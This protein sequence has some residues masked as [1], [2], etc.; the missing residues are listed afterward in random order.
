[1]PANTKKR[2]K[3][4]WTAKT[5]TNK[6]VNSIKKKKNNKKYDKK[7]IIILSVCVLSVIALFV[8]IFTVKGSHT[9][10]NPVNLKGDIAWGV[11]VSA[12][13][14]KINWE[15]VSQ[16]AEFAFIRVGYS[17]WAKGETNADKKAKYNL[18]QA[19]K[20]KVPAGVYYYSQATNEKEAKKEAEFLLKKIKGYDV[21]LP[22]VIDF[23]YPTRGKK[24]IGRLHMAHLSKKEK[25]AV[26][27]AFCDRVRKAGYT[28]GVYA[29][30]AVFESELNVK[31]FPKDVFI[32]VADYNKKNSYAG[33][34]DIWQYTSK[35]T[36][37][38]I[39]SSD[40]DLNYFYIKNRL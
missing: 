39:K 29:S 11:D 21:S 14:G 2:K 16:K 23:E 1:M 33:Y 5:K 31:D 9:R 18:S 34:Y 28:P 4:T 30:T 20:Y 27:N 8:I 12:H 25:T 40:V 10:N 6:G 22:V 35:G 3:T 7:T 36:C 26:I 13:N 15:K 38:G 17:G 32:W 37:K 19:N 24:R